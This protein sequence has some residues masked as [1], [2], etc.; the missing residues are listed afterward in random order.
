[1]SGAEQVQAAVEV[2]RPSRKRTSLSHA[3]LREKHLVRHEHTL[4]WSHAGALPEPGRIPHEST[5]GTGDLIYGLLTRR[6]LIDN[7]QSAGDTGAV[8]R[9][10]FPA[11]D[12]GSNFGSTSSSARTHSWA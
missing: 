12:L 1:M 7:E 11:S 4:G 6:R 10:A 9:L 8:P 2:F 5:H 3:L